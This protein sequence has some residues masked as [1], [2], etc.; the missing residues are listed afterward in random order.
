[1]AA[2]PCTIGIVKGIRPVRSETAF[3]RI[4]LLRAG[5]QQRNERRI[6][7]GVQ[8]P[9]QSGL[10]SLYDSILKILNGHFAAIFA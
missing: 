7:I 4:S 9:R 6:Q 5:Y 8:I 2:I 1:M 3:V 10:H